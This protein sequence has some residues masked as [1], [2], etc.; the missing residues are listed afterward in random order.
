MCPKYSMYPAPNTRP[1]GA[2]ESGLGQCGTVE[3]A[4]LLTLLLSC[5]I[6]APLQYGAQRAHRPSQACSVRRNSSPKL[7]ILP[8]PPAPRTKV[9]AGTWQI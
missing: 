1:A 9:W 4:P 2:R 6:P 7:L 3:A 5:S 8:L